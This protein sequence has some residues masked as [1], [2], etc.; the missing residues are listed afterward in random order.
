MRTIVAISGSLREGS[1]NTALLRAAVALAPE[2]VRVETCSIRGIPLYDGDEEAAHGIPA[3][4]EALKDR[5]AQADALLL[6]TPEYNQSIPGVFKNAIDWLSR[7]PKDIARVFGGKKV[8]LIGAT[9]GPVGTR[10]AQTA[11]LP[12]FRALG[13][14][15]YFGSQ[16]FVGEASKVFVDG[17]LVDETTKERL[18]KFLSGF[19]RFIDGG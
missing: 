13:M 4:V 6:A 2:G 11:W 9:P 10:L 19:A 16:L 15:P 8:G 7:P 14:N 12:V 17:E 5:I 1:F 18:T 3:P